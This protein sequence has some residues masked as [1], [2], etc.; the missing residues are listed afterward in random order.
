MKAKGCIKDE[1][2]NQKKRKRCRYEREHTGSLFHAD[3][4]RTT[5]NNPH[6]IFWL[7]DA[8][9]K[10][11]SAGEFEAPNADNA[12]KPSDKVIR[13]THISKKVSE[14]DDKDS[15]KNIRSKKNLFLNYIIFYVISAVFLF[16]AL[17]MIV[18]KKRKP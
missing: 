1:P 16:L 18:I 10:I 13:Y 2:N 5:E 9:R 11:L 8:I 15:I 14:N 7:D 6:A 3:Y 17:I 12:K 4:H